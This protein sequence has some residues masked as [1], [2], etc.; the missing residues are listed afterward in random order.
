MTVSGAVRPTQLGS[1]ESIVISN[2]VQ[3]Y[4]LRRKDTARHRFC[5]GAAS[6]VRSTCQESEWMPGEADLTPPDAPLD[7]GARPSI[8]CVE[9]PQLKFFRF[10]VTVDLLMSSSTARTHARSLQGGT[11]VDTGYQE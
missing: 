8:D 5:A 1:L 4:A 9:H 6:I 10:L 11:H 3:E 2:L 7:R